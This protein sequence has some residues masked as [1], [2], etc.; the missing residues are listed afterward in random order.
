MKKSIGPNTYLFPLPTVTVN[1][2]DEE[3]NANMMTAS[4]TG[5]VNSNPSMIS[6]SLREATFTHELIIQKKAFTVSIP[7]RKHILEMDFVG[8]ESGK[9]VDKFLA[10]GLTAVKS[11]L[12]DA[13]YVDE[14]P[15]TLECELVKYEKL[16]LHTMFIAEV[17]DVK[18]DADYLDNK[19][20]PDIK[21][22]DPVSYAHGERAYYEIGSYVGKANKMWQSTLLN[23]TMLAGDKRD[24]VNLIHEYYNKLDESLP[25]SEF[26]DL[27]NW[28]TFEMVNGDLIINSLDK[29]SNWYSDV[30]TSMFNKKHIIE[31]LTI[32]ENSNGNH[33]V[34]MDMHFSAN[35]WTPGHARSEDIIVLG[36]IKWQV[37]RHPETGQMR[38]DKY[39]I[40]E[41]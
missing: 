35:Q 32:E 41:I 2:Y 39:Y 25:L 18:I 40:I 15:I 28:N 24:I 21:K 19:G 3:G 10:T 5:V 31:K 9:K 11:N 23:N 20:L 26:M 37:S 6:V 33:T 38:I 4:W 1:V 13:P 17:K 12:V 16:G 8:T 7:S 36:K 22:L 29:Y 30:V 34:N 14:F 27:I